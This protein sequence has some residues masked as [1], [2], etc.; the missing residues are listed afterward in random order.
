MLNSIWQDVQQQFRVGNRVTQIILVNIGVFIA[1]NLAHVVLRLSPDVYQAIVH[2]FA[3]GSGWLHN[4]THPWAFLTYAF[5]HEGLW[6]VF[7]NMILFYWFGRIVGDLI[8]NQRILPLYVWGALAGGLLYF[9]TAAL[10]PYG[11]GVEGFLI[12]ASGSVMAMVVAGAFIAPE[13]AFRLILIGEVRLKYIA[14]AIVLLDVFQFGFDNND[15]GHFAHFGGM[16]M[17]YFFVA[18]LRQG[19]DLA[20]PIN[21]VIDWVTGLF[22]KPARTARRPS[23]SKSSIPV[24]GTRNRGASGGGAR[25]SPRR[26]A[27]SGGDAAGGGGLDRQARLDVI[28]DKIKADG[29]DS[30]SA[31]EREFLSLASRADDR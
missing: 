5:V 20:E 18:Q 19:N 26:S 14:L 25:R 1:V 21:R 9:V 16:F 3:V 15:G 28:L 2:F 31:E 8:G 24:G 29:I 11:D 13:Y 12:G 6:H 23:S 22:T 7:W 27:R 4:L 10:L 17:G 30:L